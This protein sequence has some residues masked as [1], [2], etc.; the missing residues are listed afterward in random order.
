MVDTKKNVCLRKIEINVELPRW[1]CTV[2]NIWEYI[3]TC[4]YN[5]VNGN[6]RCIQLLGK[7]MHGLT[8]VFVCVWVHIRPDPGKTHCDIRENL[9]TLNHFLQTFSDT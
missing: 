4:S 3:P 2:K 6:A 1:K 9:L 5:F 8:G 7:L